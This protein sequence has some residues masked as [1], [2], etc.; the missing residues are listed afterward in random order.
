MMDEDF[1]DLSIFVKDYCEDLV[2]LILD[3]P[4]KAAD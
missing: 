3:P 2:V 4:P 1:T